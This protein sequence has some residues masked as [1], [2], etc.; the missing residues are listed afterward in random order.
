MWTSA[1]SAAD[2]FSVQQYLAAKYSLPLLALTPPP[3]SSGMQSS[4]PPSPPSPPA[5]ETLPYLAASFEGSPADS[6]LGQ[7][8]SVGSAGVS[9]ASGVFGS[10]VCFKN[11]LSSFVSY[12]NAYANADS[13]T[14]NAISVSMWI[15]GNDYGYYDPFSLTDAALSSPSIQS[16]LSA[17]PSTP[18]LFRSGPVA[19]PNQWMAIVPYVLIT[20]GSWFHWVLTISACGPSTL[21]QVV[22]YI[23][24]T[25]VAFAT[26]S[27][28]LPNSS[29][30]TF[31]AGRSGDLH[32]AFSGCVDELKVFNRVLSAQ[33]AS[34][35]YACNTVVSSACAGSLA[36]PPP[37]S[38]PPPPP[39][40]RTPPPVAS[41]PPPP[42]FSPPP[43]A[44]VS[45]PPPPTS[46][47]LPPPQLFPPAIA[48]AA[49]PPRPPPPRSPAVVPQSAASPPPS[50][51]LTPAIYIYGSFK[52]VGPTT[53]NSTAVAVAIANK[54]GRPLSNV[55]V[56]EVRS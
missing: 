51:L 35:L 29:T 31:V 48:T 4:P 2:L 46:S 8:P 47:N 19:L 41:S 54:A 44:I 25:L 3:S 37:P 23:N 55:T 7:T 52:I 33:E 45:A 16:D 38:S 22:S 6:G 14:G 32:R 12:N 53:V 9:Y 17:S 40:S 36:S 18:G 34:A 50:P 28:P 39:S 13:V 5:S 42:R 1:L 20:A 10:A 49:S 21:P 24:G 43:S 15:K 11:S 56:S 30:T 26:G 27:G